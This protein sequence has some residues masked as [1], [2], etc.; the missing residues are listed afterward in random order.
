[1]NYLIFDVSAPGS[2][3]VN[4]FFY[5]TFDVAI[6]LGDFVGFVSVFGSEFL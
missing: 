2:I 5:L 6:T 1:M 3:V 4:N